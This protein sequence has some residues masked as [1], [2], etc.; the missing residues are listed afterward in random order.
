MTLEEIL[1]IDGSLKKIRKDALS[2]D[3]ESISEWA[4]YL[5]EFGSTCDDD[6]M[7]IIQ[8]DEV[9][10]DLSWIGELACCLLK[11]SNLFVTKEIADLD[12]SEQ[13]KINEDIMEAISLLA[14]DSN[15]F[16]SFYGNGTVNFNDRDVFPI[17]NGDSFTALSD[18]NF[19]SLL[20]KLAH[21]NYGGAQY[22]L[23]LFG[24]EE[25]DWLR[26]S[27]ENNFLLATYRL[28]FSCDKSE[29]EKAIAQL[30]TF[31]WNAPGNI[32]KIDWNFLDALKE[33]AHYYIKY[34]TT[35]VAE[36]RARSEAQ[37]EMLAF[38]A[39]TLTNSVA[40][41]AD[42]LRRIT[43]SLSA[44]DTGDNSARR[45]ATERLVGL[46]TS[47]SITESLVSS[48]KLYA[49]D[50]QSLKTAWE[51]D[52]DGEV[53]LRRLIALAL[54]QSLCRFFFTAEHARDFNRLLPGRDH[55][56]LSNNFIE[57]ALCY[58]LNDNKQSKQFFDWVESELPF[59]SLKI[60]GDE[61][62]LVVHDGAKYVL[63]FSIL[64]ELLTNSLKYSS[65]ERPIEL[66]CSVDRNRLNLV[67]RNQESNQ[68]SR[69]KSGNK[70]I[71]FIS[72]ICELIGGKLTE[73]EINNREF[74]ISA[75]VPI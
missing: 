17:Q 51:S 21:S 19:I 44:L 66:C 7:K 59:I 60:S 40:G 26:Q 45:R 33:A 1:N 42:S 54:R 4:Q 25:K 5:L 74:E 13:K 64:C 32:D 11:V 47:F 2:G 20:R 18:S 43:K 41:S 30:E 50:P 73:P 27:S 75:S 70:G 10:D 39:H 28:G 72:A 35:K 36:E 37:K 9:R 16:V 56:E 14:E 55:R 29:P 63:V 52:V 31:L 68:S 69:A 46:M 24:D 48:F 15:D 3:S 22:L 67:S 12:D 38:L 62:L 61:N 23:G 65:G 57:N 6:F 71:Q 8:K 53:P 49:T 34:L 58:D